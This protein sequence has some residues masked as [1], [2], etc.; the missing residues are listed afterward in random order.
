MLTHSC[1]SH[2]GRNKVGPKFWL[3]IGPSNNWPA[4]SLILR[5]ISKTG[6]TRCQILRLKCT[7]FAFRWGSLQHSPKPLAVFKGPTF[8]GREGNGGEGKEEGSAGKGEGK[9]E[10]AGGIWPT[11]KFWRGAPYGAS[12][13]FTTTNIWNNV[14]EYFSDCISTSSHCQSSGRTIMKHLMRR[15]MRRLMIHLMRHLMR[16]R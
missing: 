9:G 1:A 3:G 16:Q 13:R 6:A 7:K 10:L 4:C 11:Q 8:K 15:L 12:W 2:G 5:K 14:S